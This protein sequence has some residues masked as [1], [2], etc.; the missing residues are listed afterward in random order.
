MVHHALLETMGK[1]EDPKKA[2]EFLESIGWH[3]KEKIEV[4][5]TVEGVEVDIKEFCQRWDDAIEKEISERAVALLRDKF[6]K[7]TDLLDGVEKE[8]NRAAKDELG[9]ELDDYGW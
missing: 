1:I 7:I 2:E 3:D 5:L 4:K 6:T 9:L 8:V